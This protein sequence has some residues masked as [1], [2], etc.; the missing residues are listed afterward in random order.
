[1][2]QHNQ[3]VY[4]A[5]TFSLVREPVRMPD[6]AETVWSVVRHPGAACVL[7]LD[8]DDVIVCR[9]YRPHLGVWMLELPGG[10]VEA[11][12]TPLEAARRELREEAG[13]AAGAIAPLG[14]SAVCRGSLTSCSITTLRP[15]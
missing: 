12:E 2:T 6:G 5:R 3:T 14:R 10:T 11:G 7:P 15:T 8:G 4:Q 1:M 13:F 9:N